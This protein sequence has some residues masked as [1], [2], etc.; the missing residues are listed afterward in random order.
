MSRLHG[1]PLIS[2]L[3]LVLEPLWTELGR[4]LVFF[5]VLQWAHFIEVGKDIALDNRRRKALMGLLSLPYLFLEVAITQV[6]VE[7]FE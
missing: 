7:G 1:R 5:G 2:A 3:S 4:Y 6:C